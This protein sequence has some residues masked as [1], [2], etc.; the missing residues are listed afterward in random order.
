MIGRLL[1]FL[2]LVV[3]VLVAYLAFKYETLRPCNA[4]A[5]VVIERCVST[6]PGNL[7]EVLVGCAAINLA[8]PNAVADQLRTDAGPARC[9]ADL[10][11]YE[12][13]GHFIGEEQATTP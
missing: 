8:G 6:A 3:I 10:V 1:G 9:F 12:V 4:L 13:T 11:V 7:G 5:G 2:F